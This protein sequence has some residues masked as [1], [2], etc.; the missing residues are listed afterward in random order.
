MHNILGS[1]GKIISVNMARQIK[2][3]KDVRGYV[4]EH[5][6]IPV[7]GKAFEVRDGITELGGL[8]CW[9]LTGAGRD[10]RGLLVNHDS[11]NS[12]NRDRGVQV[13]H[14]LLHSFSNAF[15]VNVP[16]SLYVAGLPIKAKRN[17]I[18][19]DHLKSYVSIDAAS[20]VSMTGSISCNGSLTA[21]EEIWA[22]DDVEARG[23][24]AKTLTAQDGSILSVGQDINAG[25]IK[26][27]GDSGID[28][29]G[30]WVLPEHAKFELPLV[31]DEKGVVIAG[32]HVAGVIAYAANI[33][34]EK[35]LWV[36]HGIVSAQNVDAHH[37]HAQ[38]LHVMQDMS[39]GGRGYLELG[40]RV[41]GTLFMVGEDASLTYKGVFRTGTTNFELGGCVQ[42]VADD[43][44]NVEPS[45]PFDSEFNIK[46]WGPR[47]LLRHRGDKWS[48]LPK[49]PR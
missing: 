33:Y 45:L 35:K 10:T 38:R 4:Y 31:E 25:E 12:L 6:S 27:W 16:G 47:G 2:V 20:I 26:A 39:L 5:D 11:I 3:T 49:R 13:N 15:G 29:S 23:I 44:V 43:H 1:S 9:V 42:E 36:P 22:A 41:R 7:A 40:G 19:D 8:P 21:A 14:V 17:V 18:A 28:L 34:S 30:G 24:K 32:E 48:R 46:N 37:L